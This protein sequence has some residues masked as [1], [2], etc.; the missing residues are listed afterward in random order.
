MWK[1]RLKITKYC[2]D[3]IFSELIFVPTIKT[4]SNSTDFTT[5]RFFFQ[6]S[7]RYCFVQFISSK[8][9]LAEAITK[10]SVL[11]FFVSS[12]PFLLESIKFLFYKQQIPLHFSLEIGMCNTR[13]MNTDKH[14]YENHKYLISLRLTM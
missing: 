2:I 13:H 7:R 12:I 9:V 10:K 4:L 11:S 1:K 14:I 8:R 3:L 5:P 6:F